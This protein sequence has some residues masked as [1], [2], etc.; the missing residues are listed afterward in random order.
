MKLQAPLLL[1][2]CAFAI[3]PLIRN[4]LSCLGWADIFIWLALY[5]LFVSPLALAQFRD[6]NLAQ[7]EF[8]DIS[9]LK[10]PHWP[11]VFFTQYANAYNPG[12]L[13]FTGFGGGLQVLPQ[14]VGQLFWLEWPLWIFAV[15]GMSQQKYISRQVGFV[16]PALLALWFVTFPI[17]SS[18]TQGSPHVIR[19]YNFLQLP[20]ILV[21]I[22]RRLSA[23][24]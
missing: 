1:C 20:E 16:I 13:F 12:G 10:Q 15:I 21:P 8:N 24:R 4:E 19:T 3:F 9:I 23:M 2:T 14:G 6:W 22:Q 7:R 17:A 5:G 11:T 18:L